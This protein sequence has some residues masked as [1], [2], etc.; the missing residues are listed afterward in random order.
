MAVDSLD[1]GNI[2]FYL[3]NLKSMVQ[4]LRTYYW[5]DKYVNEYFLGDE[6][7][8][9]NLNT[10]FPEIFELGKAYSYFIYD[11]VGLQKDKDEY[12]DYEAAFDEIKVLTKFAKDML[13]Y[14]ATR[15][16]VV[17]PVQSATTI[18]AYMFSY[19]ENVKS[20]TI[21]EGY[22]K[23]PSRIFYR[24][25]Y[26]TG[27]EQNKCKIYLPQ[28]STTISD[29]T[30][31]IFYNAKWV[32]PILADGWKC[33]IDMRHLTTLTQEEIADMFNACDKQCSSTFT[34]AASLQ[35]IV[36]QLIED[37]LLTHTDG[38]RN[39]SVVYA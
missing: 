38:S 13:N 28:S 21:P 25:N 7:K 15:D 20:I 19:M 9:G 22:Y 2:E 5:R 33:S 35:T 34:F 6:T 10:M 24:L 3:S 39:W 16:I 32:V 30:N 8:A 1:Y 36:D 12:Y 18:K 26:S 37:G 29:N 23:L 4:E 31:A 27:S 14:E 17:P 11:Q